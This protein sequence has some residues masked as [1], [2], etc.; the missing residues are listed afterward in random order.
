MTDVLD[1][2]RHA[3][4]LLAGWCLERALLAWHRCQ[5]RRANAWL[6]ASDAARL[7]A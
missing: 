4:R 6:R 3:R 1:L 2:P 7:R 5:F